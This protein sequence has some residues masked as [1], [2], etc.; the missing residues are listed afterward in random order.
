M[1]NHQQAKE[2]Y[3][4]ALSIHLKKLGPEHTDVA[5]TLHNLG[6]LHKAIGNHQQAN[7]Y[8]ERALS[9][10][11]KKLGP[12]HTDVARTL[13]NLGNLHNATVTISRPRSITNAPCPFN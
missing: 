9:I 13:H 12:E 3:E 6:N 8:Y 4:R 11:L 1:G 2:Y 10:Q 5:L 7:E